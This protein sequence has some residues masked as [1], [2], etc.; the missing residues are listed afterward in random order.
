M[1]D[2][3]IVDGVRT[4]IGSFAGSLSESRPDDLAALTIRRL[5]ERH[6]D[7]YELGQLR[8]LQEPGR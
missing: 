8:T 4:A 1:S 6:P 7:R 2:A 3:Y 5:V